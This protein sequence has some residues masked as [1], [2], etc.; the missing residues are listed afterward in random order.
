MKPPVVR[1]V[2][3]GNR[4]FTAPIPRRTFLAATG[5]GSLAAFL[6]A[7]N[8]A[9]TASPAASTAPSVVS[10]SSAPSAI[11]SGSPRTVVINAT[12]GN[13]SKL[14]DYW[15]ALVKLWN[16]TQTSFQIQMNVTL[17][18]DPDFTTVYRTQLAQANPPDMVVSGSGA[19]FHDVIDAGLVAD[20]TPYAD[21]YGWKTRMNP[22][23]YDFLTYNGK[24]Y[25][26]GYGEVPYGFIWYNKAIF[27]KLG[28]TVPADRKT[29]EAMLTEWVGKVKGAGLQPIT[30]GNKQANLGSHILGMAELRTLTPDQFN[31]L[32][33]AIGKKGTA[34]WTDPEALKAVTQTQEWFKQGFFAKGINTFEEG[35]AWAQFAQ[36]KAAMAYAGYWGALVIPANAPKMD[37]DFFQFPDVDT[38]IPTAMFNDIGYAQFVSAKSQVKDELA[39]FL[40]FGLSQQGQKLLFEGGSGPPVTKLAADAVLPNPAWKG[41]LEVF[42]ATQGLCCPIVAYGQAEVGNSAKK[43][44]QALFDLQMTPEQWCK[45]FQGYIDAQA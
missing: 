32:N 27:S 26:Y 18:A 23:V 14:P 5:Y 42:G 29:T 40:D 43:D 37:F 10:A 16:A 3:P 1:S 45:N 2:E 4:A 33:A 19:S 28:I 8:S 12:V 7:C 13:F 6:A 21:K 39:A 9:S 36:G 35:D 31:A 20:L 38:A 30:M 44:L 34:K 15:A 11:A 24:L 25:T 17:E 22:G 41:L